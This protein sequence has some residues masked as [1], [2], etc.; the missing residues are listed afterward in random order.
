MVGA[1]CPAAIVPCS[2]PVS[3]APPPGRAPLRARRTRS[4]PRVSDLRS[5]GAARPDRRP[6]VAIVLPGGEGFS[7][8]RV[9]A[10]G[11]LVQRLSAVARAHRC[12]VLGQDSETAAGFPG[13]DF[14]PVRARLLPRLAERARYPGAVLAALRRLGPAL[15]EVHN[16]PVIA[17]R[18]AAALPRTPVV[19][20]LHNDPQEMRCA[21]T[22][23]ER[24]LLLDRLEDSRRIG[25]IAA[26]SG[27][28]SPG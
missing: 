9:G 7:P 2:S 28:G 22:P 5:H 10:V 13:L 19:L 1:C 23:G 6:V 8:G 3:R 14:C 20:V 27:S 18:L 25:V 12:V 4:G 15:I 21:H 17:L 24:R 16:R 26:R 11:L